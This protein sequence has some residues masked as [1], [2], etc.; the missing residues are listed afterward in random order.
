MGFRP[1]PGRRG[2][3]RLG[4]GAGRLAIAA[5][6]MLSRRGVGQ[7]CRALDVSACPHR[8][9]LSLALTSSLG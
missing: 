2:A 4:E 6:D 9:P 5:G 7:V 1:R 8:R 3:V